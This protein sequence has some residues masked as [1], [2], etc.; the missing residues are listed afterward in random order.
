MND[1]VL[2]RLEIRRVIL[3]SRNV[4]RLA[5][6]YRDVLGLQPF[7]GESE[8]GWVELLAGGCRL[9][10][11]DG[12]REP[13][14]GRPRVKIVFGTEDVVACRSTLVARG[15]KMGKILSFDGI[16]ICDGKDPDGNTFQISRRSLNVLCSV[17]RLRLWVSIDLRAG[18]LRGQAL[19]RRL[20]GACPITLPEERIHEGRDSS[21]GLERDGEVIPPVHFL[22]DRDGG[23]RVEV[24]LETACRFNDL[25]FG[26]QR[27]VGS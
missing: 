26:R 18:D 20:C 4:S 11:H 21:S 9:A 17:T 7:E 12:G 6:F 14:K 1:P 24:C 8:P 19:A 5:D 25:N 16:E 27:P 10:L 3:F 23:E 22:D 2:L 15:A 13:E